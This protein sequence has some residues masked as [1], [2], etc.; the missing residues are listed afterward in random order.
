MHI[1]LLL[2]QLSERE[3]YVN[4]YEVLDYFTAVFRFFY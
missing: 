4:I 1:L 3:Y 2:L